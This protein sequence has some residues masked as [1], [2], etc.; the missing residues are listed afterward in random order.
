MINLPRR[1]AVRASIALIFFVVVAS[2]SLPVLARSGGFPVRN[3][4]AT[5]PYQGFT[6]ARNAVFESVDENLF[7]AVHN[8]E[9]LY[10]A[11]DVS[12]AWPA[13]GLAFVRTYR[14]QVTYDGALGENWIH[15]FE[16]RVKLEGG[17]LHHLDADSFSVHSY[18]GTSGLVACE[19]PGVYRKA[20]LDAGSWQ[21]RDA[22]G[23]VWQFLP[24]DASRTSGKLAWVELRSGQRLECTYHA[25]TGRLV[26][27][28][29]VES[30]GAP[31]VL[32]LT[33]EYDT[34]GGLETVRDLASREW[35]YARDTRGDLVTV[36]FPEVLGTPM[37][38]E[39]GGDNDIPGGRSIGYTY[40][41]DRNQPLHD[42]NLE[43][44]KYPIDYPNGP[45][46]IQLD[47][48]DDEVL[49]AT[50]VDAAIQFATGTAELGEAV[51]IVVTD[52]R[53]IVDEYGFNAQGNAL[54]VETVTLPAY[55]PSGP[56][57]IAVDRTFNAH[58]ELLTS[59][60]PRGD[61]WVHVYDD[62]VADFFRHGNLIRE[63]HHPAP[64]SPGST[65]AQITELAYDS[66]FNVML[67]KAAPGEDAGS[68]V[69]DY[70][71]GNPV[72]N[73]LNALSNRWGLTVDL[74][75]GLGD[76]NG[77]S[78]VDQ[79]FG[80]VIT[81]SGPVISTGVPTPVMQ[82]ETFT[83]DDVSRIRSRCSA[84]GVMRVFE[85]DANG[86]LSATIDD[87]DPAASG[88]P[89]NAGTAYWSKPPSIGHVHAV[90][91]YTRNTVGAVTAQTDPRGVRTDYFVCAENRIHRI[92][93]A[94]AFDSA[95]GDAHLQALDAAGYTNLVTPAYET[96]FRYDLNGRIT[97]SDRQI[98]GSGQAA[99]AWLTEI[100]IYNRKN[101]MIESRIEKAP[102]VFA[103]TTHDYDANGGLIRTTYPEGNFDEWD[104]DEFGLLSSSIAGAS[105]PAIA[106][107]VT[108]ERNVNGSLIAEH[109]PEDFDGDLAP[110]A[111]LFVRDGF[112]RVHESISP[113]GT[114]QTESFTQ[115]NEPATR[116]MYGTLGG[117]S[118]GQND[119]SSNHLLNESTVTR[120]EAG[121]TLAS[122]LRLFV[123]DTQLSLPY[124]PTD[125]WIETTQEYDLGDNVVAV[126]DSDGSTTTY[127][128]DGLGRL[129]REEDDLGNLAEYE[130]DAAGN[131][132][133]VTLTD[134][135]PFGGSP[136]TREYVPVR[137]ALGRT[138][139]V[140]DS[141][142]GTVYAA[143]DSLGNATVRSDAVG[144]LMADPLGIVSGTI[145]STGNTKRFLYDGLGNVTD[146]YVDLRLGGVG[147]GTPDL[148]AGA[149]PSVAPPAVEL[150][151]VREPS[152]MLHTHI[153]YDLN[154]N[155]VSTTTSGKTVTFE[156]DDRDRLVK[157]TL[158]DSSRQEWT[159]F[160]DDSVATHELFDTAGQSFR[161]LEYTHDGNGR[162]VQVDITL[163]TQTD[164]EGTSSQ[165]FEYNG[166]GLETRAVDDN[167]SAPDVVVTRHYDSRGYV[168]KETLDGYDTV[169]KYDDAAN[170]VGLWLPDGSPIEYDFDELGRITEV[171]NGSSGPVIG[172][173]KYFGTTRIAEITYGNGMVYSHRNPAS[174]SPSSNGYDLAGG[175]QFLEH[176]A[177]GGAVSSSL[178]HA[179]DRSGTR[180]AS[181]Q[182][183]TGGPTH[184]TSYIYDSGRRIEAAERV[185]QPG[186]NLELAETFAI[187]A[188]SNWTALGLDDGVSS[189]TY[190][191]VSGSNDEYDSI[192]GNISSHDAAGNRT[193]D[194]WFVYRFDAF[195]R[196]VRLAHNLDP[197]TAG[198]VEGPTVLDFRYDA[199]GRRVEKS[200]LTAFRYYYAG[201]QVIEERTGTGD[202]VAQYIHGNGLDE[203]LEMRRDV[204]TDQS[205]ESYFLLT[206]TMGSTTALGDASGAVVERYRYDA[207]GRP[208][209]L[210]PT[211]VEKTSV[212]SD[213][214]LP[215]LFQGREY[216]RELAEWKLSIGT[217]Y[218]YFTEVDR[219]TG[220]YFFRARYYDPAEGRFVSRDPLSIEG[221]DSQLPWELIGRVFVDG[222]LEGPYTFVNNDPAN[223]SDPYGRSVK[224]IRLYETESAFRM[225][226]QL[227]N[228]EYKNSKIYKPG[229]GPGEGSGGGNGNGKGGG[230]NG[231]PGSNGTAGGNGKPGSNGKPGGGSP[232][233]NGTGGS[234]GKVGGNGKI[235]GGGGGGG[236]ARG[237]SVGGKIGKIGGGL[238]TG[239]GGAIL[240][241][242]GLSVTLPFLVEREN[243][244]KGTGACFSVMLFGWSAC[245]D[246]N[247][248]AFISKSTVG[249][250]KKAKK[251]KPAPTWTPEPLPPGG[252]APP[253]GPITPGPGRSVYN[254]GLRRTNDGNC[255]RKVGTESFYVKV[256]GRWYPAFRVSC[257]GMYVTAC[258]KFQ[259]DYVDSLSIEHGSAPL[260]PGG[261]SNGTV[262][263]PTVNP[264]K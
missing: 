186:S 79:A 262:T 109:G 128:W 59:T 25:T 215:Y 222:Y 90:T 171:R 33:L 166:V 178:E 214:G 229:Y 235:V 65:A 108:R 28:R 112:D 78:V 81:R 255:T 51:E 150:D 31:A 184:E 8:R 148:L 140:T 153:E 203:I 202:L 207:F 45:A 169:L 2:S 20:S 243:I 138:V 172:A 195:D 22:R 192:A 56:A 68:I 159:Y 16:H 38:P 151:L 95:F 237:G 261:S 34:S 124:T 80:N 72:T 83:Y 48:V 89:A 245:P 219:P 49:T 57:T 119:T 127:L 155:V 10:R 14:S 92:T 196:L 213:F 254:V 131:E 91:Q 29:R 223:R 96:H 118:P 204:D 135:D 102:G 193:S 194:A 185:S 7:V 123:P 54:R 101:R 191:Y 63:E 253:A 9:V 143:Y 241:Y 175:P 181:T 88:M 227:C 121:R 144:P 180:L 106:G 239:T 137:D 122:R 75:T 1:S 107:T 162:V 114:V 84:D 43:S 35:S 18:P 183:I 230:G 161:K 130:Y 69:L 94:S 147:V 205:L 176:L 11:E 189:S 177:P 157:K 154:G 44:V 260:T 5:A 66:V 210:D 206:D 145:N 146:S 100:Y 99:N 220:Q 93:R 152:G 116:K 13:G 212:G 188:R 163:P 234:N 197:L 24:I 115:Q 58:G 125:S 105:A 139:R 158:A 208:Y 62:G 77:D 87:A 4:D 242:G 221:N 257:V 224:I 12:I 3:P 110:D 187:D 170:R 156:Y 64:G 47:Y 226:S 164:I 233:R 104:Y 236:G 246:A 141:A 240:H 259:D 200:S 217:P 232:G 73:G 23:T 60:N 167:G 238:I 179:F 103:V 61:Q 21:I 142:G 86:F 36:T 39:G 247:K 15:N 30:A 71:E 120:D 198:G 67:E 249:A 50:I 173:Y 244:L 55:H 199:Y 209:F 225:I 201:D 174:G 256:E 168:I 133:R 117:P 6:P 42:H 113:V 250:C 76:Q 46:T 27:I 160:R 97:R 129:V 85:Y 82:T 182:V 111:M 52:R 126:V 165:T 98:V 26:E 132:T 216:D 251:K 149:D 74:L 32:V 248:V 231:K 19:T 41:S 263:G 136:T 264:F 190:P 17:K 258:R 218:G 134:V 70:Q 252:G 211:G 37:H 40:D 228:G 53:G